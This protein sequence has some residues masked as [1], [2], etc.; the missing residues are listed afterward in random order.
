MRTGSTASMVRWSAVLIPLVD[1]ALVLSGVLDL[2]TGLVVAVVLEVVLA[3]V[4]VVE[5]RAFRA[6][7]RQARALG[8]SRSD[9]TVRG[10]E[11]VWPPVILRLARAELGLLRSLWWAVR[12]RRA[13][14]PGEVALPYADR[15]TVLLGT[16]AVLG[17][18]EL[19]VVHVLTARWPTLRWTLFA[20]GVYALLWVVGFGLS[21]RQHPHL[22]RDRELV[23]RFGHLRSVT[24]P[25]DQLV[26]V[27]AAPSSGHARNVL[28]TDG[29][30]VMAVMG[31][32]N[33]ELRFHPAV[34]FQGRPVGR[35][36]CYADDP[37]GVVRLLRDR[38]VGSG[39]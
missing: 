26:A 9:A 18:L 8:K 28:L 22:L 39:G 1:L 14:R 12:G 3:V 2:R 37:R 19:G 33:L 38:A 24:L 30:L 16:V 17:A 34:E 32:T 4:V 23:L 36:S 20:L 25:L 27:T 35:V 7:Y 5:A 29:G 21:L 11:A 6:A 10:L 15:F 31:D 13:V